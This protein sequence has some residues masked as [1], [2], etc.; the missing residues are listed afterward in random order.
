MADFDDVARA[1][2]SYQTFVEAMNAGREILRRA[3]VPDP[4]PIPDFDVV[5]RRL[6]ASLRKEL[7]AA[8]QVDRTVSPAEGRNA[9]AEAIRLWQPLIKR[10]FARPVTTQP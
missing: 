8:L 1:R 6:N 5:F 2:A 3:G 7:Y 4:P 10:A 9:R